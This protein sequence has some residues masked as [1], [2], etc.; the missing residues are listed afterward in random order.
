MKSLF[1]SFLAFGL[2]SILYAQN[3]DSKTTNDT[4]I[5]QNLPY[6]QQ[7][8]VND[9]PVIV[10]KLEHIAAQYNIKEAPIYKEKSQVTYDVIF[11]ESNGKIIATYNKSGEIV[12]SIEE[13]KNL[14]LPLQVSATISKTYPGWS[15]I[16]NIHKIVYTKNKAKKMYTIQIKNNNLTKEL[17]FELED[18]PNAN[19]LAVN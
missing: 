7:V 6:L 10:M 13:Y 15:F 16:S 17:K 19:Y 14:K 12:S 9:S 4:G 18:S 5:V 2:S 8:K 3:P 1:L 11:E